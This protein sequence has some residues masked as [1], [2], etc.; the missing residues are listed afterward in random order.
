[1]GA[2]KHFGVKPTPRAL[3]DALLTSGKGRAAIDLNDPDGLI[4][5]HRKISGADGPL[6]LRPII[7]IIL[8]PI[9]WWRGKS[10][11]VACIWKAWIL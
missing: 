5:V 2:L 7:I 8:F 6:M 4:E 3:L 9:Y 11:Y 1:M 10:E